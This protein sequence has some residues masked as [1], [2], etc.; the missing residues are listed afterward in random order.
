MRTIVLITLVITLLASIATAQDS[1]SYK[2]EDLNFEIKVPEDSVDWEMKTIDEKKFPQLRVHFYSEFADSNAYAAIM[3]QVQKMTPKMA[4]TKIGRVASNW[5]NALEGHLANPRK[6]TETIEQFAGVES[7]HAFVEGDFHSGTTTRSWRVFKNGKMLYTIIIDRHLA[8]TKDEDVAEEIAEIVKSFKFGEIRKVAG[9]R[10]AKGDNAPKGP[11]DKG[12]SKKEKPKGDPELLKKKPFS[13]DFW[14]YK[15]IKPK[16]TLE[17]PISAEDKQNAIK[18]SWQGDINTVRFGIRI[19]AW[20]LKSRKFTIDQL[21]KS[22]LKW[23]KTRVKDSKMN[24]R[25]DKYTKMPL[26]KKGT[27]L[28]LRG[29]TTRGE[30]WIYIIIECKNDR[31]YLIEIYSMG[32]VGQKTWGKA[33]EEFIKNFKPQKK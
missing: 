18:N 28:E 8:A 31:M 12:G 24:D 27:Y 22:K 19:Y 32:D 25:N 15:C 11:G 10:K 13:S 5:K 16:G 33:T 9:D 6:R 14:R 3:V 20:S 30:R 4:R 17:L 21:V 7:Y 1:T 26:V 2:S 23:W 29:R